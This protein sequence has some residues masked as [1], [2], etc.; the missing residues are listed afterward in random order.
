MHRIRLRRRRLYRKYQICRF[1]TTFL[2]LLHT[3]VFVFHI[4]LSAPNAVAFNDRVFI[5]TSFVIF[6]SFIFHDVADC[7]RAFGV[8]VLYPPFFCV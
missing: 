5:L 8:R 7:Q 6:H 2:L 1:I 4:Y 3:F